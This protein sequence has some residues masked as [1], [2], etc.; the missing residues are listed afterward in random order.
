MN[1]TEFKM[2]AE[3]MRDVTIFLLLVPVSYVVISKLDDFP[4]VEVTFTSTFELHDIVNYLR[5]I[6]DGHVMVETVNTKGKY[7]GNRRQ[8][9]V[10]PYCKKSG[11]LM[12]KELVGNDY[13]LREDGTVSESHDQSDTIS[14]RLECDSCGADS[15][16]SDYPEMKPLLDKVLEATD[17]E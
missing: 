4:D 17:G 11:E 3:C 1:S 15:D 6:P 13:A 9:V 12:V 10:C 5:L 14:Y 7:D 8:A 2:R 16:D